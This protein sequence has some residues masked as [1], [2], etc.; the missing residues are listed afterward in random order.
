MADVTRGTVRAHL[1]RLASDEPIYTRAHDIAGELNGS[2]KA[3]AY[4]LT[5]LEGEMDEITLE[6]WGRSNSIPWKITRD[7]RSI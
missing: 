2:A 4:Y 5:E 1:E 6:R 7:S 3:V